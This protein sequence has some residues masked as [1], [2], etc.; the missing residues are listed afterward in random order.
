MGTLI[1]IKN[2]DFSENAIRQIPISGRTYED[3]VISNNQIHSD[4]HLSNSG[5]VATAPYWGQIFH[6]TDF[7]DVP[8]NAKVIV[9]TISS[10]N[11]L[12]NGVSSRN[13]YPIVVFKNGSDTLTPISDRNNVMTI[14]STI[15]STAPDTSKFVFNKGTVEINIPQDATQYRIEWVAGYYNDWNPSFSSI[16]MTL[17]VLKIGIDTEL[18]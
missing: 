8:A 6:Y 7:Y 16:C 13:Y 9:G 12:L 1:V 10:A 18:I 2:A 3:I 15:S 14:A 4:G 11:G 5:T 17:P